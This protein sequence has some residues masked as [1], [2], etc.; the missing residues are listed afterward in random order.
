MEE[1]KKR[2]FLILIHI[3]EK[4]SVYVVGRGETIPGWGQSGCLL[5]EDPLAVLYA[6]GEILLNQAFSLPPFWNG[7][8]YGYSPCIALLQADQSVV[9][10]GLLG[11]QSHDN[12][13]A[14]IVSRDG[15]G[16]VMEHSIHEGFHFSNKALGIALN[17]EVQRQVASNTAAIADDGSV[18]VMVFSPD[19]SS[20]TL[21]FHP[22]IIAVDSTTAVLDRADHPVEIGRAH[23]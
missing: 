20:S 17:K 4:H 8:L 5:K 11:C 3:L 12:R 23:V 2:M 6:S 9:S 14:P 18:W 13:D 7:L 15:N 21:H 19:R 10:E 22:L 1:S 16:L